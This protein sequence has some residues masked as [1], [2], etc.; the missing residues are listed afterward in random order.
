MLDYLQAHRGPSVS[1][2][3]KISS[4]AEHKASYLLVQTRVSCV[5]DSK[6]DVQPVE[7]IYMLA[8]RVSRVPQA[9]IRCMWVQVGTRGWTIPAENM[10]DVQPLQL[11]LYT[12]YT[13]LVMSVR[14]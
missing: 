13:T 5:S 8:T 2:P 10:L 7:G 14:L 6:K 9:I 11:L 1:L 3:R 4:S 12:S